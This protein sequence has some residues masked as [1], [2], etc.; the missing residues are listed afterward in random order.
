MLLRENEL[1]WRLQKPRRG[2]TI[3][4]PHSSLYA[5]LLQI[6]PAL[7]NVLVLAAVWAG[8]NRFVWYPFWAFPNLVLAVL[9]ANH[10]P[11]V[12]ITALFVVLPGLL[13]GPSRTDT[14]AMLY[15]VPFSLVFGLWC[16]R[17]GILCVSTRSRTFSDALHNVPFAQLHVEMD[18]DQKSGL[19]R[20]YVKD[21]EPSWWIVT[22]GVGVWK[23]L[24]WESSTETEAS[25]IAEEFRAWGIGVPDLPPRIPVQIVEIVEADKRLRLLAYGGHVSSIVA[26]LAFL[27][28]M[29]RGVRQAHKEPD[30]VGLLRCVQIMIAFLFLSVLPFATYLWRLGRQS[31][32]N[33]QMP[34][35]G[36]R[37]LSDMKLIQGDKAAARGRRMA[38]IGFVLLVIGLIGGLYAPYKLGSLYGE[39]LRSATPHVSNHK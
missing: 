38:V 24:A 18:R 9:V 30:P 21:P 35:P 17:P 25:T 10:P 6:A 33:R 4:Q 28:W 14:E 13:V 20:I 12:L 23:C 27:W 31:M 19:Y 32:R 26:L 2:F 22:A 16:F 39:P 5:H 3:R 36:M 8:V 15:A 37:I 7:V 29:A 34:P 1:G 11:K